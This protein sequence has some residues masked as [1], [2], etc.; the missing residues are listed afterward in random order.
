MSHVW[1]MTTLNSESEVLDVLT[2]LYGRNW[3][4]RGQAKPYNAL[5]PSIDREPRQDLSRIEKLELER[6]SIDLFRSTSRFFT[7]PG[8]QGALTDDI[9]ALM[10]LQHYGVP[11]RLLDWSNSPWIAA[12]FAVQDHDNE[13]GE[14]W[15]FD[16][17]LFELEG[18]QQWRNWP[19]TT[20][21]RSGHDD[22]FRAGITAFSLK[23]PPD[24]IICGYYYEGFPRQIAQGG[25]YTLTSRFG[26]DHAKAIESLLIDRS[27]CHLYVI[28][29]SIKTKLRELLHEKHGF[30]R[31]SLFPDTAG[32]AQT[33][34]TKL[35]TG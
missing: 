13:D 19:E 17:P 5:V 4:C 9:I 6:R 7:S 1:N 2:E 26:R 3:L 24:W 10:V 15:S 23:E 32:A 8:E 12:Y 28:R 30:W 16:R 27:H 21:D 29:A 18:K 11:T 33:V 25:V 31:G 20:I 14:L 35:F 22:K 34:K